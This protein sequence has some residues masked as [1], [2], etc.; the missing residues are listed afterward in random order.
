M[1]SSETSA[2]TLIL[3]DS[4]AKSSLIPAEL[5]SDIYNIAIGGATSIE[6]YYALS[7]YL[8]NHSA[9]DNAIIIFA[10]YHFCSID[11]W[12]QTLYY[13]YL[14]LSELSEVEQ[15]AYSFPDKSVH[16]NGWAAD[17]LSFKLRLPNKYL[18]AIYQA[19]VNGRYS[20]NMDKYSSVQ[21]DLGYTE[22]GSENGNDGLNYET[23]HEYFD[24]SPLVVN[25][26]DKLLDL[27]SENNIKVTI[28]QAPF[29][30]ASSEVVTERFLSEYK[31]FLMKV[32]EKHP[33]FTVETDV[34]VYDNKYFGDNNHMNRKGAEKFTKEFSDKYSF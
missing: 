30:K 3:G 34:P 32:K 6:M 33:D 13:N 10:P 5:G 26:Y 24:Y 28:A 17:L 27:C 29:N 22:F 12:Q 23:H 8:S 20:E 4:R 21:N 19:G 15:T 7:N 11:N 18:D 25:Y 1:S 14:S 16:Y 2:K 31:T 9:P